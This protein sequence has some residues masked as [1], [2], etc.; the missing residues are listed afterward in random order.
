MTAA[1][2]VSAMPAPFVLQRGTD[3]SGTRYATLDYRSGDDR[4][5]S[6]ALMFDDDNAAE[7]LLALGAACTKV[8]AWMVTGEDDQ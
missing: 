6:F 8:A 5:V 2:P 7:E 1:K 3:A 4:Y